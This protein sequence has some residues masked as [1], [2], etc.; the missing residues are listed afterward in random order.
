MKTKWFFVVSLVALTSLVLSACGAT[1]AGSNMKTEIGAGEG[2]VSIISWAG[3]WSCIE[4]PPFGFIPG[5]TMADKERLRG[6]SK[7]IKAGS[8]SECIPQLRDN[9]RVREADHFTQTRHLRSWGDVKMRPSS[10]CRGHCFFALDRS[11]SQ[12]KSVVG[13][14][15]NVPPTAPLTAG[16]TVPFGP[17]TTQRCVST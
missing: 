7:A 12:S 4:A 14:A 13:D 15:G 1:A 11:L 8:P 9:L 5:R 16:R 17:A 6:L 10:R 2:E 3:F